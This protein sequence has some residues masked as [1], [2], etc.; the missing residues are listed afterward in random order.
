ML[1]LAEASIL[2]DAAAVSTV[3]AE[4]WLTTTK[5]KFRSC[6]L[7]EKQDD[8]TSICPLGREIPLKL[9][10]ENDITQGTSIY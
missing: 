8:I 7:L 2:G 5:R 1:E 10:E 6:V 4:N 3:S 9:E